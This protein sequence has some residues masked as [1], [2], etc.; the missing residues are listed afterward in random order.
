MPLGLCLQNAHDSAPNAKR[1]RTDAGVPLAGKFPIDMSMHAENRWALLCPWAD[2][3]LC[4]YRD[5]RMSYILSHSH[6]MLSLM[7]DCALGHCDDCDCVP[8][9]ERVAARMKLDPTVPAKSVIL[10]QVERSL[11]AEG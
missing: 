8:S 6:S 3:M 9:S 4:F 2:H 1:P 7:V 10:M 11:G 5:A